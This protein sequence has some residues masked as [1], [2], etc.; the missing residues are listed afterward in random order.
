MPHIL[1]VEDDTAVRL[2]FLEILFDAGYEV[3][4]AGSYETGGALLDSGTA[5]DLLITDRRLIGGDGLALAA[6]ASAY[7][8]PVLLVTGDP[9]DLEGVAY[10]VLAKPMRADAFLAAVRA[11][12]AGGA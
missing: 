7:G 5:F 8:I 11:A 1:L 6:K 12:L 3:D 10:A 9:T 4:T 2:V